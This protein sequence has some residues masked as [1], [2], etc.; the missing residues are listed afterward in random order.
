MNILISD[1]TLVYETWLVVRTLKDAS[2]IVGNIENL[3]Y[4]K[5]SETSEDKIRYLSEIY[6]KK[7]SCKIIY[8]CNREK[9]DNAIRMLITGGLNGKYVDD[10]FFL[11]SERELNTLITDLPAVVESSELASSAVLMDFFNRYM[12]EGGKGVSKGYLQVVKNAAI[13]MSESYHAKSRE[14]LQMS[15]SAAEIF[16]NSIELISQMKEQQARLESD[17]KNLKDRKNEIDAFNIK[18]SVGSSVMFYPRVNYLKSK[19]IIRIKDL[20]RCS[21]LTSF[22]L[23][24]REYL[25]KIKSVRPKLIFIEGIGK[26]IETKYSDYDWV[27]SVNKN[28]SRNFYGNVTFTNCPTSMIIS[29]LV[30]DTNFDIVVIVDRTINYKDNLLNSKGIDLYAV[31]GESTIKKFKLHKNRCISSVKEIEGTMFMIPYFDDYPK[32]DDQ[33][34]N[35][36]LKECATLYEMIYANRNQ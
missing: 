21:Y 14:L 1:T 22:A 23:G 15:E 16:G 25:E 30:D 20:S 2:D 33:R 4:H 6:K 35:K 28:D 29:R 13:E 9:V 24:F 34:V 36:Y 7:T 27:T 32:R 12:T 31:S 3:I 26:F 11:E 8:I 18:P 10:E 19:P 5:S 17:L